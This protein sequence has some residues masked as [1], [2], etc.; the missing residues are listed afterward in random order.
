MRADALALGEQLERRGL[1]FKPHFWFSTEWFSPD[2]IP[3]IDGFGEK[4]A[5]LV[6]G[7]YG[8]LEH[9]PASADEWKVKPRGAARLAANLAEHRD[10]AL[11]YRK[12][13]TLIDDVPLKESLEDLRFMGV[14]RERYLAWC[15]S[16][17]VE[18]MRETPKRWA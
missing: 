8:H 12:L 13:A 17:G 7:A 1:R 9:I 14:P 16:L 3:G 4:S 11:L 18:G 5:A 15:E 2:G 10:D 6:I